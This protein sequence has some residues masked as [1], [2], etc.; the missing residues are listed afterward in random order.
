M[1]IIGSEENAAST[2][3]YRLR[4]LRGLANDDVRLS[5]DTGLFFEFYLRLYFLMVHKFDRLV[6]HVVHF[7]ARC[8]GCFEIR[9][10][11]L[12]S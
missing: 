4:L 2:S 9:H 1:N 7:G 6:E 8:S 12:I 3:I 11:V 5:N 10:V